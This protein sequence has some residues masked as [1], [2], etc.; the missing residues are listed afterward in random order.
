MSNILITGM[1]SPHTSMSANVRSLSFAGCVTLVLTLQGH[2]VTQADPDVKWKKEDLDN[3][4][5]VLVGLSPLTSL[6]ANKVYGA[7]NVISIL[8]GSDKLRIF[9]DAPEPAKITAS[10]RAISKTPD[11]LTKSFYSNRRG[12]DVASQSAVKKRLL[13]VVE[14]L[15]A[16][17]WPVTIYP[18]LPWG[19][20]DSIA[21]QLPDLVGNSLQEVNL[22]SYFIQEPISVD[23]R[24]DKWVVET[25]STK[26]VDS[27][28]A[29]LES[30]TVP[31]K[32]NKGWTDT[33]VLSQIAGS[34]GALI[35]PYKGGTWWSYRLIQCL[36]TLTPI[37]TDWKESRLLGEPWSHL[38]SYIE[39]ASPEE[40]AV[41]AQGQRETYIGSIPSKRDA[42]I[43]LSDALGLYS[44]KDK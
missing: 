20:I 11:N 33:Q 6:S 12:F 1:S 5:V 15:L 30:P 38:A 10:L 2:S 19:S 16:A 34:M 32:W 18:S 25:Y 17:E 21:T 35:S 8:K 9:I 39:S 13:K 23:E 36:N 43:T 24:R 3:Y 42:A 26:W 41:L 27:A 40:R 28:I 4:D 37:A 44:R 31:M 7:L 14:D 29:M 22:D